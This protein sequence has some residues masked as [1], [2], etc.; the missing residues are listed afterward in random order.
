MNWD[1]LV[2]QAASIEGRGEG[3]HAALV[4]F[5]FGAELDYNSVTPPLNLSLI[6]ANV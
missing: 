2:P 5:L 4:G 1:I 6:T 3:T